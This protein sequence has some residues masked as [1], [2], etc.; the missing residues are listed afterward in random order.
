MLNQNDL[1]KGTQILLESQPYEVMET[2]FMCKGRGSS[3]VQTRLKNILTGNIIP[4]TFHPGESIEEAEITKVKIIFLYSHRDKYFFCYENDK[5]K[6]FELSSEKLGSQAQFLK[7]NLPADGLVFNDEIVNIS[8]PIKI[9]LKVK[10]APPGVKG[11]RAQ[12]GTKIAI[13]ESGAQINVP[14]FVEEGELIEVNTEKGEY[15]RRVTE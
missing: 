4:R 8:L 1:K 2:A 12:G 10:E 14:L 5:S 11:D 15:V 6:R 7:P 13:L 9:I 3:A